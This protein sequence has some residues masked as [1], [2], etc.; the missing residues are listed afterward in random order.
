MPGRQREVEG[1]SGQTKRGGGMD[2]WEG[3]PCE[4]EELPFFNGL[5]KRRG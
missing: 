3:R 4:K 5:V 1:A 2:A